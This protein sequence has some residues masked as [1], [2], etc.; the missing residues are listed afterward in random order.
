M[1]TAVA[2]PTSSMIEMTTEDAIQFL[3]SHNIRLRSSMAPRPWSSDD[4][5]ANRLSEERDAH[6]RSSKG[7]RSPTGVIPTKQDPNN[8]RPTPNLNIMIPAQDD[9]NSVSHTLA[10]RSRSRSRSTSISASEIS[11]PSTGGVSIAKSRSQMTSSSA[12]STSSSQLPS[13]RRFKSSSRSLVTASST[14]S[15]VPASSTRSLAAVDADSRACPTTI[16]RRA[17][18]D[19]DFLRSITPLPLCPPDANA[20]GSRPDGDQRRLWNRLFG[21]LGSQRAGE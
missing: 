18:S 16:A 19:R 2:Q 21:C 15:L 5:N 7:N 13:E 20:S 6:K 9:S 14:R 10:A 3:A 1:D 11:L 8:A 17:A 12:S 4:L